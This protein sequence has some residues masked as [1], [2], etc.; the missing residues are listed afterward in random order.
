MTTKHHFFAWKSLEYGPLLSYGTIE[1]SN[2]LSALISYNPINS[3]R[4]SGMLKIGTQ[5]TKR[6]I[7]E[8]ANDQKAKSF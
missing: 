6:N 1:A 8:R 4:R 3:F 7:K 5:A 2:S